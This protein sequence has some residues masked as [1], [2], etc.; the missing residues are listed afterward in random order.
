M[1][2]VRYTGFRDR[3]PGRHEG[4]AQSYHFSVKL[5]VCNRSKININKLKITLVE[6]I[7]SE[8]R[9]VSLQLDLWQRLVSRF[10]LISN[11]KPLLYLRQTRSPSESLL[12]N[13]TCSPQD[14]LIC[15]IEK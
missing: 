14:Q 9:T 6:F 8:Y 1:K 5:I 2:Q 12:R 15:T 10:S 11:E 7:F 3:S 13:L 4:G